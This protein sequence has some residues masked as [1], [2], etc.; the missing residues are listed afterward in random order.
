MDTHIIV[1]ASATFEV[2]QGQGGRWTVI[3]AH[4]TRSTVAESMV[5]LQFTPGDNPLAW[6]SGWAVSI[7]REVNNIEGVPA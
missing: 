3:A 6:P 5:G 1:L 4:R 7:Q 2:K